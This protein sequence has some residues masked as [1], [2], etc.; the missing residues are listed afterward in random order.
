MKNVCL[1]AAVFLMSLFSCNTD[2]TSLSSAQQESIKKEVKEAANAMI[3]AVEEVNAEALLKCWED[4]PDFRA[5]SNST[6][7]SYKEM[8]E[9]LS[10]SFKDYS[11]MKFVTAEETLTILDVRTVIYFLKGTV[12]ENFKDGH[13]ELDNPLIWQIVYKK[14]NGRWKAV[15]AVETFTSW[16]LADNSG[17]DQVALDKQFFGK[18]KIVM[19]KDT[20]TYWEAQPYGT[21]MA[22][23]LRT[24]VKGKVIS[25]GKQLF[26][27]N[28]KLGKFMGTTVNLGKSPVFQAVWFTSDKKIKMSSP[29]DLRNP[30]NSSYQAEGEFK[31]PDVFTQTEFL[32]GKQVKKL[33]YQRVK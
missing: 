16:A 23:T 17:L 27:Y 32:D 1:F 2:N 19:G 24:E 31:S 5:I 22:T 30:Y 25:Q 10:K 13:S 21:G 18:W 9:V 4:S 3:K 12:T 33:D 15:N 6:S 11:N 20:V 29:P 26:G 7:A 28:S 14:K 8:A